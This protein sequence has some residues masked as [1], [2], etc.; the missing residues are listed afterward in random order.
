[1][2]LAIDLSLCLLG[3]QLPSGDVLAALKAM[4]AQNTSHAKALSELGFTEQRL[5]G[6]KVISKRQL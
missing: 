3:E 1:M 6:E 4:G 5:D 2:C